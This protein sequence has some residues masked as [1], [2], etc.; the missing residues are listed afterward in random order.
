MTTVQPELTV[1]IMRQQLA[2]V[3][4]GMINRVATNV[5]NH[6]NNRD[7]FLRALPVVDWAA[8][9]PKFK[10]IPAYSES[11]VRYVAEQKFNDAQDCAILFYLTGDAKYARC[12]GDILH[13]AIKM[14]LS[15]ISKKLSITHIKM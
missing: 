6:Q 5:T 7:T 13:N 8:A 9:T 14:S 4:T 15:K 11:S 3:R 12:G 10:T 1:D 2:A